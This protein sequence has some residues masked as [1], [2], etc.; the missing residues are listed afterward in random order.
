MWM[1]SL[2]QVTAIPRETQLI[3]KRTFSTPRATNEPD[4][5]AGIPVKWNEKKS[6][7]AAYLTKRVGS[8]NAA[9]SADAAAVAGEQ[10]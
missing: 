1:E 10:K 9:C 2:I 8:V 6:A 5:A 4:P 7:L 3:R